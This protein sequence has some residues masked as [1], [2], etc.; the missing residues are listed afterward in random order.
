MQ[1]DQWEVCSIL[2]VVC[3][4]YCSTPRTNRLENPLLLLR[5]TTISALR[6]NVSRA[7]KLCYLT[8]HRGISSKCAMSAAAQVHRFDS[9]LSC[10]PRFLIVRNVEI[11]AR[12]YFAWNKCLVLLS[13]RAICNACRVTDGWTDGKSMYTT[14]LPHPRNASFLTILLLFAFGK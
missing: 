11:S 12:F 1:R 2:S 14:H 6:P 9:F 4:V 3:S 10:A 13:A 5:R 8:P 7:D